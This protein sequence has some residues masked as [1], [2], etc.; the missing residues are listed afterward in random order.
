MRRSLYDRNLVAL[1]GTTNLCVFALLLLQTFSSTSAVA[2]PNEE[3]R[4]Y[5]AELSQQIFLI[6]R[7][8]P[9]TRFASC[10]DT[11][12]LTAEECKT[13]LDFILFSINL[14]WS[15]SYDLPEAKFWSNKNYDFEKGKNE[16]FQVNQDYLNLF[17][18]NRQLY[19]QRKRFFFNFNLKSEFTKFSDCILKRC[20]DLLKLNALHRREISDSWDEG[21]EFEYCLLNLVETDLTLGGLKIAN[22]PK[23]EIRE[24]ATNGKLPKCPVSSSVKERFMKVV[25]SFWPNQPK[26]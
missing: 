22:M 8:F 16:G 14:V 7:A 12:I 1:P 24:L 10:S 4:K 6:S 11:K 9:E 26:L 23:S 13:T 3:V 15:L 18:N 19:L 17:Y 2:S 25:Y 20:G 5:G 21:V